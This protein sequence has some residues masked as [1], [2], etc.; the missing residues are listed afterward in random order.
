MSAAWQQNYIG[1]RYALLGY[2]GL[3]RREQVI[4]STPG[5]RHRNIGR[6]S[7][8]IRDCC[9]QDRV[10]RVAGS[11]ERGHIV[12]GLFGRDLGGLAHNGGID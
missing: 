4:A 5:D 12:T 9:C 11:Q 7:A 10:Y 8:R 6:D 1:L 3:A 2:P